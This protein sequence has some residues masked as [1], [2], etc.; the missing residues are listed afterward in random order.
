MTPKIFLALNVFKILKEIKT[1]RLHHKLTD[2]E[3]RI[4]IEPI[5]FLATLLALFL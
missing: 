1:V 2:I 5:C 4:K 3:I